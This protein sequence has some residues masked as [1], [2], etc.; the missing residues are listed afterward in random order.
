M[1]AFPQ[2]LLD[3]P[4]LLSQPVGHGFAPNREL[5]LPRCAAY[6][7]ETEKVERIRLSLIT[8]PSS[9]DRKTSKFDEPGLLQVQLQVE[10]EQTLPQLLNKPLGFYPVLEAQNEIIAIPHNDHIAPGIP[11]P[12]PV[13]PKVQNIVEI[14]I[15]QQRAD[16]PTLRRPFLH[17]SP[18]ITFQHPGI[19]PLLNVAHHTPVPDPVLDKPN[20]PTVVDR[21]EE[22]PDVCIEHPVDL[23]LLN[24]PHQRIQRMMW[25]TPRAKSIGKSLEV[26]L[27]G[28]IEHLNH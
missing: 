25:A 13:N 12:P 9:F 5:P 3:L 11:P 27:V 18:L 24:R 17:S 20:Q 8:P 6:V 1:H 10:I 21:I 7:C 4:Q 22:T 28:G 23:P 14:D 16:A 2:G 15:C 19:Q 26:H